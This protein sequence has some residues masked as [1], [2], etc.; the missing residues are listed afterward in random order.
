MKNITFA[1]K[2][3]QFNTIG[4][5]IP[6]EIVENFGITVETP[7]KIIV[8]DDRIIYQKLVV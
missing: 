2:L 3:N 6:K 5:T 4:L 7:F 1:R 8:E